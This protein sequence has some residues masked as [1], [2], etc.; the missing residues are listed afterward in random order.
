M[1]QLEF[2]GAPPAGCDTHEIETYQIQGYRRFLS[3]AQ[4]QRGKTASVKYFPL[5]S[6]PS[7]P[8][9]IPSII[10]LLKYV[11]INLKGTQTYHC[12]PLE[13]LN[14]NKI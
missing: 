11:P 12:N 14:R 3:G 7:T 5:P 4:L 6:H 9:P 13:I 2:Y 1:N 8:T 10:N